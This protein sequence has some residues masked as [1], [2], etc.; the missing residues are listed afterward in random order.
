VLLE[1]TLHGSIHALS[2]VLSLSKPSLFGRASRVS[3]HVKQMAAHLDLPNRWEIEVA[4]LLSDLGSIILP[5]DTVDRLHQGETLS[6]AEQAM[7]SRV[8]AVTEQLLANIPRLEGVREILAAQHKS[9][10]TAGAD[11]P[12]GARLLRIATD[13]DVLEARLGSSD[14]AI[15]TMRGRSDYDP[16]LLESFAELLGNIDHNQRTVREIRAAALRPGMV[17]TT[18]VLL[19]TGVVLAVR[20][21][22]VT[23][24]FLERLRNLPRG[25]VREPLRVMTTGHDDPVR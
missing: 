8:P 12:V 22:E 23:Q 4:A 19:N 25:A 17:F 1:Q 5:D 7:T 16:S 9:F 10:R 13:H 2:E 14:M 24:S 20:G 15:D 3:K 11:V 21:F 18:D 6:E